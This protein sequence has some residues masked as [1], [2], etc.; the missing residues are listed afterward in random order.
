MA[1]SGEKYPVGIF[2]KLPGVNVISCK[3]CNLHPFQVKL[4]AYSAK[5][6]FPDGSSCRAFYFQA[7][8]LCSE[9]S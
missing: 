7:G 2:E 4:V 5:K 3:Y 9:K 1:V 8:Q 6:K